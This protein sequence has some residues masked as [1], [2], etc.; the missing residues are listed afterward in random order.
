M[1]PNSVVH[2]MIV[3]SSSPRCFRSWIRAAAPRAMPRASGPWSRS[4]SSC[5]SQLRRGKPLSLPAPDLHEA[6][7]ALQ[8]PPRGQALAAEV[9]H[10]LRGV[11]LLRPCPSR[12]GRVPYIS[13]IVRRLLG[14]VERFRRGELHLRGEF[15]AADAGIEPLV[16]RARRG[17]L[18]I[19]CARGRRRPRASLAGVMKSPR[20]SGKRSAIGVLRAGINDRALMLRR[21]K[22][23]VPV[24]RAVRRQPAMIRQHDER[25]Q[26][27]VHRARARS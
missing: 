5:E 18:A 3:S 2:R 1:R 26:I 14:N 19:E 11:D 7:A 27:V 23:R 4:T 16:A 12:R 25:R 10:L 6:H 17:V 22:R 15:V 20:L 9:V 8:Q 13:R 21:Q 24:L